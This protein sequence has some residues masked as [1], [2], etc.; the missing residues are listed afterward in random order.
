MEKD[1]GKILKGEFQ[2]TTTEIVLAIK[3]FNGRVGVDIREYAQSEQYTGPTKKGLRIPADKFDEFKTMI[4]SIDPNDLK[5][6]PEPS[7][8]QV[9]PPA[10]KG[11]EDDA[12]V[13]EDGTM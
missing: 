3:E 5:V 8:E 6:E 1:I 4:N 7:E 13:A 10:E 11:D 9:A 2:G 12:G